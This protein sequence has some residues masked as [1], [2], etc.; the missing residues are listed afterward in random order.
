MPE[1]HFTWKGKCNVPHSLIKNTKEKLP[2]SLEIQKKIPKYLN[3]SNIFTFRAGDI[4]SLCPP[5]NINK[6]EIDFLVEGLASTIHKLEK[7]T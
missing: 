3:D 2:P 7:E 1:N 4:I 5:L 6:D